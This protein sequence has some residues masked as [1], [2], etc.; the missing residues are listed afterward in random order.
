MNI[1]EAAKLVVGEIAREEKTDVKSFDPTI[2][3]LIA[4]ML[5]ELFK[6]CKQK[7]EHVVNACKNPNMFHRWAVKRAMKKAC[8]GEDELETRMGR[9]SVM[10]AVFKAGAGATP[11]QVEA[12]MIESHSY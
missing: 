8:C 2:F 4:N 10:D 11:T 3:V 7:P 1:E 9:K 12:L 6:N 5:V